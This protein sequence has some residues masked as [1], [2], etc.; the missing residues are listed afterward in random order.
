MSLYKK[1]PGNKWFDGYDGEEVILFE[2]FT[3]C[4]Q[5]SVLLT[6]CDK[7]PPYVEVKGGQVAISSPIYIFTTNLPPEDQYKG[8][9]ISQFRRDAFM[10]RLDEV[11]CTH[12]KEMVMEPPL[13]SSGPTRMSSKPVNKT[14]L[15]IETVV[16]TFI[17][18]NHPK[19]IAAR[20]KKCPQDCVIT[21]VE[22]K[23]CAGIGESTLPIPLDMKLEHVRDDLGLPPLRHKQRRPH[24]DIFDTNNDPGAFHGDDPD[25]TQNGNAQERE[26]KRQKLWGKGAVA[27]I[28]G[29]T[30][31]C[32]DIC[33]C[34]HE[35][36]ACCSD[37]HHKYCINGGGLLACPLPD[38]IPKE[39]QTHS[40]DSGED[41]PK[42]QV[43]VCVLHSI[44][45]CEQCEKE[46]LT[47]KKPYSEYFKNIDD[48]C[49]GDESC[50]EEDSDGEVH[51]KA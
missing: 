38:C 37:C 46:Y 3:S 12:I 2:E 36:V 23:A 48:W 21:C 6:L 39:I 18:D 43:P 45:G 27:I 40:A 25:A 17:S 20:E 29:N 34:E 8:D 10:R 24:F 30:D 42:A 35:G 28:E 22:R 14:Y 11:F 51:P 26:L 19:F 1:C 49:S 50:F 4:F 7:L 31:H 5:L 32:P 47:D 15:E 13:Y 16:R 44:P 41:N 33:N 9:N